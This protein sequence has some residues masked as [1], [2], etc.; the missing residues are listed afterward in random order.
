MKYRKDELCYIWLDSFLGLEYVHKKRIFD[1]ISEAPEISAVLTGAKEYLIAEIGES[2]FNTVKNSANSAYLDYV[3]SGLS[4]RGIRALTYVSEDYPQS[5]KDTPAPPLVLYARG[6]VSL[7]GK[8]IFGIVGSRKS[9]PL[10]VKLAERYTESLVKAG[11]TIVTG[12]AEGIDCTAIK[13]AL[14]CGGNIISV[15][16]GG[17]D[18]IYPKNHLSLAEEV[19]KKGLII[20]EHPPEIA[21]QRFMFPVRNRIIAGLSR[22]VL[23]VSGGMKSGT[24]YTAEYAE[25][26]GRDVFCV[27]YSVGVQSGAICNELI[28]RGAMLT[29]TPQDILDLYGKAISDNEPELNEEELKVVRALASGP[30]HIEKISNYAGKQV[31]EIMPLLSSLEIKG[32]I[33]KTG[34]NVFGLTRTVS[35][36]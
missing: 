13:S 22:G 19:A 20:S 7:F 6:D 9:L 17:F 10:S 1:M 8:E 28:K 2:A 30:L 36:E 15:I 34:V 32:I 35:E 27:P 31:F 33:A 21:P 29:D 16:A 18:N 25:E 12:I 5:L 26:Y 14:S 11:F 3:L 24:L 4:A 23:I